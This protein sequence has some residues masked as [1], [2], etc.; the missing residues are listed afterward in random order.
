MEFISKVDTCARKYHR[1]D[2]VFDTYQAS[3]LKS[4]TRSKRGQGARRRVTGTGKLPRNWRDILRHSANKA[5]LFDYL[6]EKVVEHNSDN[7][8]IVT[9][10][11]EALSNHPEY[12]LSEISPCS[13]E[14]AD[15]RVFLHVKDAVKE[16]FKTV[17]ISANDTDVL[18]IAVATFSHRPRTEFEVDP[19]A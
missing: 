13:H 1:T 7:R 19:S 12:S 8:V 6:A 14:E 10:G 11:P 5:E 18:V 4:E 3:S 9:K 15:T 16:G 2:I 17:M